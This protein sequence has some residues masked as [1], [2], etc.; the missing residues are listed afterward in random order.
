MAI[1]HLGRTP[2]LQVM[3]TGS[4]AAGDVRVVV[5]FTIDPP[6]RGPFLTLTVDQWTALQHLARTISW[7]AA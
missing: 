1:D 4:P 5:D 7:P 2:G 6:R 3:R